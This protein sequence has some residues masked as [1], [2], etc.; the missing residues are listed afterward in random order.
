VSRRYL[1]Y[2]LVLSA[3]WGASFLFIKVGVRDYEP[4]ALVFLR[5]LFAALTLAPIAAVLRM[6]G[7]LWTSWRE[8]AIMAALNS[9]I[10][11]WLLSFGETRID[12]GL[13]AVIQAAAPIFTVLIAI[14]YDPSQRASGARLAGI[15]VGFLGV[16]L[17]VGAQRGGDVVAALAV[18]ATALCYAA[19]ALFGG[20][21]LTHLEPLGMAF[22][23]MVAATLLIAPFG[24]AQLPGDTPGWKPTLSILVL[25]VVGT[26]IAYILY[27]AIILGA[28]ASRAILVTYLVPAIALLY[29]AVFLDEA[30]TAVALGGLALVLA[31]VALGTGTIGTARR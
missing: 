15:L 8:L 24:L 4:A 13:A 30:V 9:A 27:Y 28:G 25:G 3:I 10:P 2:L 22:G 6:T 31:G 20:R 14:R 11:F 16:A 1:T 29:G 12:S 23:T 17:L 7:G 21:R 26:G 19:A 18:V 5:V